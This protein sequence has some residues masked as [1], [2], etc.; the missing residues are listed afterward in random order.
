MSLPTPAG[1]HGLVVVKLK[2][3][4][5]YTPC[6]SAPVRCA[7]VASCPVGKFAEIAS[8]VPNYA[9]HAN[10]RISFQPRS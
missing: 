10:K 9:S 2:R 8:R 5:E 3:K 6:P 4:V 7:L 1:T